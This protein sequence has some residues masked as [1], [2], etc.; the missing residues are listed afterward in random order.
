MNAQQEIATLREQLNAAVGALRAEQSNE[1]H[2]S[3]CDDCTADA[4]GFWACPEQS[5]LTTVA[6]QLRAAILAAAASDGQGAAVPEQPAGSCSRCN[7]PVVYT[8]TS[9]VVSENGFSC[10]NGCRLPAPD[11]AQKGEVG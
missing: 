3:E 7:G 1:D 8:G 6:N 4:Q 11:A 2:S 10:A 9:Y 5:R